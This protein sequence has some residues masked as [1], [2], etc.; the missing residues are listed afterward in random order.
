MLEAHR[1][2]VH[3]AEAEGRRAHARPEESA[4]G[5]HRVVRDWRVH[6]AGVAEHDLPL[7][8]ALGGIEETRFVRGAEDAAWHREG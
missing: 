2:S 6:I 5:C 8:Y 1:G 4:E 7:D 3:S